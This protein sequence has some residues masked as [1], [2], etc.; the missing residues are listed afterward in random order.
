MAR[1]CPILPLILEGRGNMYKITLYD[2]N[3]CPICD[4]VTYFFTE[5]LDEFEKNWRPHAYE[6]QWERYARSKAGEIVTDYYSDSPKLNIV[7]EDK[8]AE[9]L[10]E[11]ELVLRD[12]QFTLFNAYRWESEIYAE[13]THI[14]FRGIKFKGECYL[15]GSYKMKG[16]CQENF[17][18]EAEKD[19]KTVGIYGNPII[20]CNV[21][22]KTLWY[23][24]EEGRAFYVYHKEDFKE[25]SLETYC[26]VTVGVYPEEKLLDGSINLESDETMVCLMRDIPG[27]AG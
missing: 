25:D 9:I 24:T 10:F 22:E 19:Y 20:N 5:D 27:E 8:N 7:Q 21:Q 12:K 13:E 23:K 4:G 11:K 14:V 16:V 26:F 1:S 18:S 6:E 17:F 15:I 2:R 3:C